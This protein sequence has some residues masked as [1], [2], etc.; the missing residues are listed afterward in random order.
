MENML[1]EIQKLMESNGLDCTLENAKE[2][3]N[4]TLCVSNVVKK[5]VL[6]SVKNQYDLR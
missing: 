3:L 4:T 6:N 2:I 1:K 5:S